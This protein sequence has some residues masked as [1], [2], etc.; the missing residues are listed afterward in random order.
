MHLYYSKQHTNKATKGRLTNTFSLFFA[1]Q[2]LLNINKI[3][4]YI[5]MAKYGI[6]IVAKFAIGIVPNTLDRIVINENK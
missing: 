2:N 4:K 6:G 5:N 3:E 1:M